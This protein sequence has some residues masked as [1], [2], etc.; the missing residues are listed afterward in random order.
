VSDR[1]S[2]DLLNDIVAPQAVDWWP[3]APAWYVLAV[4][5]GLALL[6]LSWRGWR[7]WKQNRYRRLALKELASISASPDSDSLARIPGL[8]KRTALR[9]WPRPLV[10]SLSGADWHEFLDHTSGTRIFCSGAGTVLDSLSYGSSPAEPPSASERE[11][12]LKAA[13]FWLRRHEPGAK[14]I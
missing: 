4:V 3:L 8:L 1:T 10:A 6:V 12:A 13:E 5:L 11:S 9:A 7:K 14:G 2:L